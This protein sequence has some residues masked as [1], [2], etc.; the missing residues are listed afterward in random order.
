MEST[1]ENYKKITKFL[2]ENNPVN[3]SIGIQLLKSS[4]DVDLLVKFLTTPCHISYKLYYIL[5]PFFQ[6]FPDIWLTVSSKLPDF[7]RKGVESFL[8]HRILN[9]DLISSLESFFDQC[10]EIVKEYN[11]DFPLL[12]T[13]LLSEENEVGYYCYVKKGQEIKNGIGWSVYIE[14]RYEGP[15]E[16]I[17]VEEWQVNA[18][19]HKFELI[20]YFNQTNQK[21]PEA[22]MK[23]V[24]NNKV[25]N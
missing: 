21:F 14:S 13:N 16:V 9:V 4:K 6:E 3:F 18:I 22:W 11:Q 15:A 19:F 17:Y 8:P 7:R 2:D 10:N 24:E 12:T 25:E 20:F 1:E 23:K 5:T